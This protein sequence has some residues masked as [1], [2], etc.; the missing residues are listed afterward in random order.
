MREISEVG[1]GFFLLYCAVC[2]L[3]KGEIRT[4]VLGVCAA[5]TLLSVLI[6]REQIVASILAGGF[7]GSGFLVV[8]YIT[9]EALGYADSILLTILGIFVGAERLLVLMLLSFGTA[10]LFA[11]VGI[12]CRKWNRKKTL[13][14]V[15]F[16]LLGYV[17]VMII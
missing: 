14:F 12:T 17:G 10:A 3:K 4:K 1:M 7:I 5:V 9:H 2:D 11:L 6:C 15:P 8:S 16:L 13:P